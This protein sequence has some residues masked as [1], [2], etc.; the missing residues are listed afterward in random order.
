MCF[1][2]VSFSLCGSINHQVCQVAT[3]PVP[4]HGTL[5]PENQFH[6][7]R[8]LVSSRKNTSFY[9]SQG[10]TTKGRVLLQTIMGWMFVFFL[11]S[12]TDILS[13]YVIVQGLCL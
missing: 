7:D 1:N 6:T 9:E 4:F 3:L 2:D 12:C 11:N 8:L 10:I 13:I 5:V